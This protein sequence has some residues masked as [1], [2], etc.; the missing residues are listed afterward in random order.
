MSIIEEALRRLKDPTITAPP[1]ASPGTER[2][3]APTAHSWPAAPPL[4][5]RAASPPKATNALVGVTVAIIALTA[6]FIA[7]GAFWMGRTMSGHPAAPEAKAANEPSVAS[8]SPPVLTETTPPPV[9]APAAREPDKEELVL[10]GIVEGE[11][12]PYAVIN[13]AIVGVG[14]QIKGSTL[15]AIGN[16]A[17]KVRRPDGTEIA[18]SLPK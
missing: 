2:R 3:E 1:Q 6:V 5:G 9:A 18:L 16:G 8:G 4:S 17:V 13:G 7:G 12:E 10:T 11:G 14:E 15:L